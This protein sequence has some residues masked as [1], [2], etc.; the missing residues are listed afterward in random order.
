MFKLIEAAQRAKEEEEMSPV[1]NIEDS[2]QQD[3][4]SVTQTTEKL[5][6]RQRDD[7]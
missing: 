4:T 2:T 6:P 5:N 3:S 7:H 1:S